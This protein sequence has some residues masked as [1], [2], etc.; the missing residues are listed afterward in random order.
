MGHRICLKI[1]SKTIAW[2]FY[3]KH[4]FN[5]FKRLLRYTN[6]SGTEISI[7][8]P[9]FVVQH[10]PQC[11]N[12]SR[13]YGSELTFYVCGEPRYES[14]VGCCDS[15]R[16]WPVEMDDRCYQFTN[17]P[18]PTD[19]DY[20]RYAW[21][22][23][24]WSLPRST[25]KY[26]KLSV[27]DS[28]KHENRT[29][30][31]NQ[32]KDEIDIDIYGKNSN[33]HIPGYHSG[34]LDS[35]SAAIEHYCFHLSMESTQAIDYVTEKFVDAIM[36]DS[37]PV[38]IDGAPNIYHYA[39]HGS[40]VTDMNHIDWNNWI[41][42]YTNRKNLVLK[43]KKYI[44]DHLNIFSYFNAITDDLSLL[45]L[46]RPIT[47]R[48]IESDYCNKPV[49]RPRVSLC[50]Y[51]KNRIFHTMK[52]IRRAIEVL[53][54]DDELIFVDYSDPN[55]IGKWVA[56]LGDPRI[57]V[58]KVN[59]RKFYNPAHARNC[60][61]INASR[62]ILAF[63]DI[64]NLITH[65]LI[66]EIRGLKKYEFYSYSDGTDHTAGFIVLWRDDYIE[67][68]GY[69]EAL[70]GWGYEDVSMKNSLS[71]MGIER[72][73]LT[74]RVIVP[75]DDLYHSTSQFSGSVFSNKRLNNDQ[76]YK[77]IKTLRERHPYKH[78][79]HRDW[80]QFAYFVEDEKILNIDT[81]QF[82]SPEEAQRIA[83]VEENIVGW[84]SDAVLVRKS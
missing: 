7:N 41:T 22:F 30:F 61:G 15:Q 69:E 47:I 3:H 44:L 20:I 23:C 55:D 56:S 57:K 28:G 81:I 31:I 66:E 59:D 13:F 1:G 49:L 24:Q 63:M 51:S 52:S 21:S 14:M 29:R 83:E 25:N 12:Y 5:L 46:K 4:D 54:V 67:I 60:A 27:I 18:S 50:T 36:C 48:Q 32:I 78:N 42:E 19:T 79:V 17:S 80:G 68:N 64:D 70:A 9:D 37:I 40:Y 34:D 62:E 43:Q 72:K 38:Y 45:D 53:G 73:S 71:I 77:L 33:H 16:P 11:L 39:I 74:N 6:V 82:D 26:K 75:D 76:N 58:V 2:E 35:K 84:I 65:E 8:K 10:S